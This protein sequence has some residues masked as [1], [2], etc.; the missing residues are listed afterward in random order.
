MIYTWASKYFLNQLVHYPS[1]EDFHNELVFE[2]QLEI[3]SIDT[4]GQALETTD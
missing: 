3:V 4:N 1:T 2:E